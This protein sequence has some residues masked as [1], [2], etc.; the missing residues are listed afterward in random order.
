M[1]DLTGD[2]KYEVAVFLMKTCVT[3][4]YSDEKHETPASKAVAPTVPSPVVT[5]EWPPALLEL[6]E[7]LER[8]HE[9]PAPPLVEPSEDVTLHLKELYRILAVKSCAICTET[10]CHAAMNC[11]MR[12][13]YMLKRNGK[14]R[15]RMGWCQICDTED[16]HSDGQCAVLSEVSPGQ[17]DL[18]VCPECLWPKGSRYFAAVHANGDDHEWFVANL[19]SMMGLYLYRRQ[20]HGFAN[21]Y[22]LRSKL[23]QRRRLDCVS[24]GQLLADLNDY[25]T[26]FF[27]TFISLHSARSG[28]VERA[29]SWPRRLFTQKAEDT[30]RFLKSVGWDS[31]R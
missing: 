24:S 1:I 13:M 14:N 16:A 2:D 23:N 18:D 25:M 15:G 10:E 12:R 21:W 20:P 29:V 11:M 22:Q 28:P 4:G 7:H 5:N 26:T 3:E 9:A 19:K 30:E 31:S 17:W 27:G 8:T 6:L